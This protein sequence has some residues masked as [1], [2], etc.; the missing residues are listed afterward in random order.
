MSYEKFN[1]KIIEDMTDII[2]RT[3][4]IDLKTLDN[5]KD[6]VNELGGEI[7]EK[8][9][10]NLSNITK[11]NE[12]FTII[13][14]SR[15]KDESKKLWIAFELGNLFIN[16][17]YLVDH[18]KWDSYRV[19]EVYINESKNDDRVA[20]LFAISLLTPRDEF[21]SKM[22][23]YYKG[24]GIYNIKKVAEYFNLEEKIVEIR[25]INLGLLAKGK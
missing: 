25:G 12:G 1:M 17:G 9:S 23:E 7:K 8:E 11:R 14:S 5:M 15:L 13:I 10:V 16:M 24:D 18:Q 22:K 4:N 2:R 3:C 20:L 6:I 19:D 21:I